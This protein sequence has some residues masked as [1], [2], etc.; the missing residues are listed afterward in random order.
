MCGWMDIV[1]LDWFEGVV[2]AQ[3]EVGVEVVEGVQVG[4]VGG[5]EVCT[6][7]P[8]AVFQEFCVTL[9]VRKE[10]ADILFRISVGLSLDVVVNGSE[11]SSFRWFEFSA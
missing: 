1:L 11:S 9:G 2:W 7:V 10:G 6:L 4:V 5:C 8:D 3:A